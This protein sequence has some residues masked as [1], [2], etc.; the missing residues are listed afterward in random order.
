METL[1]APFRINPGLMIWTL[2]VFGILLFLLSK[3]LFPMIVKATVDRESA[4]KKDLADAEQ[5]R[6]D[7]TA[8]LEEQ[9]SL[10]ASSRG[11]AKAIVAEARE[12]AERERATAVE[13]TRQE[14]EELLDRARREIGAERERAVAEIRREAVDIAIAAASKVVGSRLDTAADRKIVEDYITS[15]GAAK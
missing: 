14:Q 1:P 13:K 15:I 8:A 4:I 6:N 11:E 10:L 3:Y 7:A 12:A 5:A 2:I 9:R